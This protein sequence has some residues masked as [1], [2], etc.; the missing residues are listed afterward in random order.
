MSRIMHANGKCGY[1]GIER[2]WQ[3]L[4]AGRSNDRQKGFTFK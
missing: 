1:V 3:R 4:V 2:F